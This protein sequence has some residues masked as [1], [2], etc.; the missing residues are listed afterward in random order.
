MPHAPSPQQLDAF[1]RTRPGPLVLF[2][3]FS[4]RDAGDGQALRE[5]LAALATRQGGRLRWAATEEEILAGRLPQFQQAARLHFPSSAA[6]LAFVDSAGHRD[7]AGRCA[8]LQVAVLGEQPRAVAIA[9]ALMAKL[10]PH[11]PFDNTV[12]PGEEPGVDVSTVMPTSQAI[13]ALRAHPQQDTPVVMV[14]WLRFKPVASDPPGTPPASGK[15]AYQRYGKVAMTTTHSLGAKLLFAARYRQILIG[16]D[17]DPAI[18]RWDEFALMQYPGRAT[19]GQMASLRR[20]RRALA[21]REAG[22][23][24]HGQGLTVTRPAAEFVWRR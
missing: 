20:Y 1:Q 4:P 21:D 2:H 23:A 6:A 24:E 10:L 18:G 7:L 5:A 17:G 15:T 9:S 12:E 16:N 3:E 8:A 11:W 22:L 19:F 14:N 13:A